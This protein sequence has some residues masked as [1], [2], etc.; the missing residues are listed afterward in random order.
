VG[1][2]SRLRVFVVGVGG[3]DCIVIAPPR[4]GTE[5]RVMLFDC[6]SGAGADEARANVNAV[7]DL[8]SAGDG[9]TLR[10]MVALTHL[11]D[12]HTS[13]VNDVIRYVDS[14]GTVV[15][16]IVHGGG[17][18]DGQGGVVTVLLRRA[19]Y[20]LY[21]FNN[22][23]ECTADKCW[24]DA[25]PDLKSSFQSFGGDPASGIKFSV[26]SANVGSDANSRSAV[27]CV[28]DTRANFKFCTHG[29]GTQAG[30]VEGHSHSQLWD[31]FGRH[32]HR[33]TSHRPRIITRSTHTLIPHHCSPMLHVADLDLSR[34]HTLLCSASAVD[35]AEHYG[36]PSCG[37]QQ[38][39]IVAA[40]STGPPA[41]APAAAPVAAPAAAPVAVPAAVPASSYRLGCVYKHNG[42]LTA[43]LGDSTDA[44]LPFTAWQRTV[45]TTFLNG[46]T[47][48]QVRLLSTGGD[49]RRQITIA[50]VAGTPTSSPAGAAA[51][52]A[53]ASSGVGRM[54]NLCLWEGSTAPG[55]ASGG[56]ASAAGV[57][58]TM[59]VNV[60]VDA[61]DTGM[62]ASTRSVAAAA[63]A[64]VGAGGAAGGGTGVGG[65][66]EEDGGAAAPVVT[67]LLL[68]V[69]PPATGG[70]GAGG[71]AGTT[72]VLPA[73]AAARPGG[74][75]GGGRT[76]K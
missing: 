39:A 12:D 7:L 1:D 49:G 72:G 18:T 33:V 73:A 58:D 62:S 54:G 10:L 76:G 57:T 43:A 70:A 69:C 50:L 59:T 65:A 21:A 66:G 36:H 5:Q 24:T 46:N 19:G 47:G 56:G 71:G 26:V 48:R 53:G 25:P 68:E 20:T 34:T 35:H 55:G 14:K 30:K 45:A 67:E 60:A 74:A 17:S 2:H 16:D 41:R 6:G 64:K 11:D 29:D 4:V 31:E 42:G 63:A 9:V 51:G 28:A 37:A 27:L 44:M 32:T 75:G 22:G 38:A 3:G 23:A 8:L 40:L 52:A 15:S 61:A 13:L